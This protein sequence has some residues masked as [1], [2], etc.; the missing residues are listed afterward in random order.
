MHRNLILHSSSARYSTL[1]RYGANDDDFSSDRPSV[2]AD[3]FGSFSVIVPP[4][5]TDV[6][7]SDVLPE[8]TPAV[9]TSARFSADHP[10]KP[11]VHECNAEAFSWHE[12]DN[13]DSDEIAAKKRLVHPVQNQYMCGSCWAMALAAVIS[14]CLVVSGSVSWRPD[15]DPTYLMMIVSDR[16]GNGKCAGG[17]PAQVALALEKTTVS[18]ASC[19]DYSWCSNDSSLCTSAEAAK[20]FD[21]KL[22]DELNDRVPRADRR[23]ACY[24]E[25]KKYAYK[26]DGGTDVLYIDDSSVTVEVFSNMVKAHLTDFGPSLAGYAVLANF[27]DGRFTANGGVY[28]D[29]AVYRR[30]GSVAEFRDDAASELRLKG[31]HAVRVVGWGVAKNILYDTDSYGDV[32]YWVAANS[33]GDRWGEMKGYFRMAMY[34]FNKFAQ[35]D[36]RVRIGGFP[37]GGMVL[38]RATSAPSI[39]DMPSIDSNDL[40]RIKRRRSD[41]YYRADQTDTPSVAIEPTVESNSSYRAPL[42]VIIAILAIVGLTAAVYAARAGRRR[43]LK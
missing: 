18:D 39:A 20:H 17:N 13:G 32:P 29:R 26:I 40:E 16:D 5:N 27:V 31:M 14:D 12:T 42:G 8:H 9:A 36:R 19:I 23:G 30:D 38:V 15:I 41:A 21:S 7:F 22:A 35:F 34:P 33:W 28:F 37:V 1:S 2:V 3:S 24:F 11:H 25:S 6:R 10:H 4:L 43:G